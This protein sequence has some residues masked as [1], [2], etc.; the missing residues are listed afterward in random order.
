MAINYKHSFFLGEFHSCYV[1][2]AERPK[3]QCGQGWFLPRAFREELV[4]ASHS[5]PEA[6]GVL[7]L[8]EHV[9]PVFPVVAH[10]VF[11]LCMSASVS[12]CPLF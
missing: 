9:L 10:V 8:V 5:V 3:S 2:E 4:P 7:L 11:A 1:L 12:R 6:S